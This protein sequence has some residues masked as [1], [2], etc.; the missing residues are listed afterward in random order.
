MWHRLEH[1]GCDRPGRDRTRYR[2][3]RCHHRRRPRRSGDPAILKF[4]LD[5]SDELD[6]AVGPRQLL[7]AAWDENAADGIGDGRTDPQQVDDAALTAAR[8]LCAVGGDLREP[9]S[10]IAA[11]SVYGESADDNRR[12]AELARSWVTS[13]T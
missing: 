9:E 11:V 12:V 13:P 4:A 10:W 2:R 7:P 5:G 1:G 8:C 3:R 6:R